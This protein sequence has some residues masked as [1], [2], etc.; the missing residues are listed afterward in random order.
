MD[1]AQGVVDPLMAGGVEGTD[2]TTSV[3]VP[4]VPHEF[5][6]ATVTEQVEKDAGQSTEIAL[7]LFGPTMLPH[8]VFHA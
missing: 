3:L 6:A 4:P 2:E 1:P 8:V 5:T 7:R